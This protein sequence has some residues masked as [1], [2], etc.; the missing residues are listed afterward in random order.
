MVMSLL[1]RLR[2]DRR[3][4]ALVEFAV[5]L[6]IL[7]LLLLGGTEV[8]RYVLLN[9]KLDRVVTSTSDLTSQSDD[10]TTT[11]LNNIFAATARIM[12]P[13]NYSRDGI[14]IVSS[15]GLVNGAPRIHWQRTGGGTLSRAS[16]IGVQGG[17][18]TLPSGL[19]I[20]AGDNVIIA[21][22]FYAFTPWLWRQMP[23]GDLYHRAI[24]RPRL[25]NL[26]AIN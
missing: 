22:A 3:G 4:A 12:L 15:V 2:A 8:A 19:T 18:A 1:A 16:R 14:V 25:S 20:A 5:S 24:T 23:A 11:E 9:Q 13:Y 26:T 7:T 21:E 6:P 10:I 17:T